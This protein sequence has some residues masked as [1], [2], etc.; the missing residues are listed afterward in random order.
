ME[1]KML[2]PAEV[3]E[4]LNVTSKTVVR[5]LTANELKGLKLGPRLWRVK[6]S[7]FKAFVQEKSRLQGE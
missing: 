5:W 4:R 3:A 1:E 2:T 6:E 7:D